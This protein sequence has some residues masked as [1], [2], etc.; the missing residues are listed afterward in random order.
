MVEPIQEFQ[1]TDHQL[2]LDF[3][4]EDNLVKTGLNEVN[5]AL[6]NPEKTA[7]RNKLKKLQ[8]EFDSA[9]KLLDAIKHSKYVSPENKRTIREKYLNGLKT[10]NVYLNIIDE[11]DYHES[12]ERAPLFYKEFQN[13]M[14]KELQSEKIG[15]KDQKINN[16]LSEFGESVEK[17]AP[18]I[19]EL[20]RACALSQ[21]LGFSDKEISD[22]DF[23]LANIDNELLSRLGNAS[24]FRLY[25]GR[26]AKR[27]AE[28][29][30]DKE[31][32]E[33]DMHSANNCLDELIAI[34]E[35]KYPPIAELYKYVKKNIWRV[36][37]L[38]KKYFEYKNRTEK[39]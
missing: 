2:V 20:A 26:A 3:E 27:A 10:A 33:V 36:M 39:I 19:F 38:S 6:M 30:L 12:Q 21:E 15:L 32:I 37:D 11:T 5:Q 4:K 24:L 14:Q 35:N 28:G 31:E 18:T 1:E 25:I 17:E 22:F 29:G 34:Y 16:I 13:K 7:A 8:L 9:Q 23:E